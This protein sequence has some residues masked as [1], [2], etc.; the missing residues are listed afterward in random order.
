MCRE[1]FRRNLYGNF[2][3][4]KCSGYNP[5]EGEYKGDA[6]D[7]PNLYG[8]AFYGGAAFYYSAVQRFTIN[9]GKKEYN[10]END[11]YDVWFLPAYDEMES[12]MKLAKRYKS[13]LLIWIEPHGAESL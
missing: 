9:N 7:Y 10:V 8:S 2:L 13:A 11:I 3:K 1:P 4:F 6:D 5:I 12:F